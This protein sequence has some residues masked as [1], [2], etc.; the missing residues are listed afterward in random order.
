[1]VFGAGDL[2]FVA[3][4]KSRSLS[5]PPILGCNCGPSDGLRDDSME[6]GLRG[7][8][9]TTSSPAVKVDEKNASAAGKSSSQVANRTAGAGSPTMMGSRPIFGS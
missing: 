8:S 6:G 3:P 4:R 2:F 5:P 7:F 1:M 9:A